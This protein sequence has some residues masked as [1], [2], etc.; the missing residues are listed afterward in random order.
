MGNHQ[1]SAVPLAL[2]G[3]LVPLCQQHIVHQV[4]YAASYAAMDA[5]TRG[6]KQ[7]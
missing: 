7:R 5:S 2:S 3:L 6:S 4:T 1:I